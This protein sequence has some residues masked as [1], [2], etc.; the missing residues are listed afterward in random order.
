M[1]QRHG[2]VVW[3]GELAGQT[4]TMNAGILHDGIV[5]MVLNTI[6]KMWP[7]PIHGAILV[8][9]RIRLVHAHSFRC[10][11]SVAADLRACLSRFPV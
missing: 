5:K 4:N 7:D 8:C 9:N 2:V 11:L 6:T 10:L 3:G 1:H